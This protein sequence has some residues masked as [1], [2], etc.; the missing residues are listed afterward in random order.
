M[1]IQILGRT[2]RLP[3]GETDLVKFK[4]TGAKITDQHRAVF[5]LARQ[6]GE[7]V[8]RK[9]LPPNVEEQSFGMMFVYA[10]TADLKTGTYDWSLR[11]MLDLEI[12]AEGRIEG[13]RGQATLEDRG[14]FELGQVA[15]GAR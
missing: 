6:N 10:D 9:V 13:A 11:V 7:I 15:G 12:S 2:I 3:R 1:A 5:T 4:V 8:L 14:R